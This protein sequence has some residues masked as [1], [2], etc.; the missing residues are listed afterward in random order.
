M[1][2]GT[3]VSGYAA[4]AATAPD[5]AHQGAMSEVGADHGQ[6]TSSN[7]PSAVD[8]IRSQRPVSASTAERLHTLQQSIG[9]PGVSRLL[10]AGL[11]PVQRVSATQAKKD[12]DGDVKRLWPFEYG[13][14]RQ[15]RGADQVR[16]RYARSMEDD[17]TSQTLSHQSFLVYDAIAGEKEK[18]NRGDNLEREVQGMLINNRLLFASNFNESMDMLKPHTTDG[19]KD[20][21][22]GLVSTHQSDDGRYRG[23]GQEYL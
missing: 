8:A 6:A 14:G 16:K 1:A 18:N 13:G 3:N 9:N 23:G 12:I 7:S 10:G 11:P 15:G 19:S 4:G 20:T 5:H 2:A 22:P 17:R 21:Y